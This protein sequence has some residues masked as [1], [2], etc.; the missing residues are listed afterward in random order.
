M[1]KGSVCSRSHG[2]Q[3]TCNSWMPI[4]TIFDNISS[5]RFEIKVVLLGSVKMEVL[6][7]PWN[8]SKPPAKKAEAKTTLPKAYT[9]RLYRRKPLLQ[10]WTTQWSWKS[11]VASTPVGPVDSWLVAGFFYIGEWDWARF[12][13]LSWCSPALPVGSK[14]NSSAAFVP[15]MLWQLFLYYL[16]SKFKLEWDSHFC[17]APSK[18][19]GSV[20]HNKQRALPGYHV[21]L[22]QGRIAEAK[23]WALLQTTIRSVPWQYGSGPNP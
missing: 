17:Q 12:A 15:P 14:N 1:G 20:Q 3:V 22:L 19:I 8:A 21:L 16:L 23:I 4:L 13:I 11:S 9:F 10:N 2:S 18:H 7:A 5:V 6:I